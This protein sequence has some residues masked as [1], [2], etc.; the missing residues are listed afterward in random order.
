MTGKSRLDYYTASALRQFVLLLAALKILMFRYAGQSPVVVAFPV[1]HREREEFRKII[2]PFSKFVGR[3]HS[4][5]CAGRMSAQSALERV[6]GA[7]SESYAHRGCGLKRSLRN[8]RAGRQPTRTRFFQV[9]LE[10]RDQRKCGSPVIV[11]CVGSGAARPISFELHRR[12]RPGCTE[13]CE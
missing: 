11:D 13:R 5:T 2:G 10:Y 12:R 6:R 1:A 4:R 7:L 8:Y 9:M 3:Y